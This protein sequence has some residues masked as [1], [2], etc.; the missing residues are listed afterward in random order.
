MNIDVENEKDIADFRNE[1]ECKLL[2]AMI[3]NKKIVPLGPRNERI[4]LKKGKF[5]EYYANFAIPALL[6]QCN[7]DRRKTSESV[8]AQMIFTWDSEN[9][10][11]DSKRFLTYETRA[12]GASLTFLRFH[13]NAPEYMFKKDGLFDCTAQELYDENFDLMFCLRAKFTYEELLLAGFDE[14]V[15]KPVYEIFNSPDWD[16]S[17]KT[18][19]RLLKEKHKF[20]W[21]FFRMNNT[22]AELQQESEVF[23]DIEILWY[24]KNYLTKLNVVGIGE[25]LKSYWEEK[26]PND[27]QTR[28]SRA[29]TE[30]GNQKNPVFTMKTSQSYASL[31]NSGRRA[32]GSSKSIFDIEN[33]EMYTK[34]SETKDGLIMTEVESVY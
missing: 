17:K 24:Y 11:F 19:L 30:H 34:T 5:P 7:E 9:K 12:A 15:L 22:I 13:M 33:I 16:G 2:Y 18:M 20:E 26:F 32:R 21:Q 31:V 1:P 3:K 27:G 6:H 8:L 28:Y 29:K 4:F 10:T 14:E 25:K 23:D